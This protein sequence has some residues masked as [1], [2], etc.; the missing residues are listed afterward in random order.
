MGY[1]AYMNSKDEARGRSRL[2]N[3]SNGVIRSL[4]GRNVGTKG[5][6]PKQFQTGAKDLTIELVCN[7]HKV[8]TKGILI[9][10][11]S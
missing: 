8:R 6:S 3:K 10:L 2:Q 4:D 11:R 7:R 9:R 1:L 5:K